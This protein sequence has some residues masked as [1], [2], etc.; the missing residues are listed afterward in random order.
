[1]KMLNQRKSILSVSSKLLDAGLIYEGQGNISVFDRE[2]GLVAITPS[3]VPYNKREVKD[4]CIVDVE[5]NVIEGEWKPT[6]ETPLH[7]IYYKKRPG[8]NAVI[9]THAP[10]ATVF[11]IFGSE[12]MPMVLTEAAMNLGNSVPIA[13]YARPGSDELA[14]ITLKAVGDGFA[15]IMAHH[16][17]ITVG[18]TLEIAYAASIAVETTAETLIFARA[19]DREPNP[20]SDQEVKELYKLYQDHK[21][22]KSA[23]KI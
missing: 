4:I 23:K 17:V 1:M 19:M 12:P 13:P 20:I 22:Q 2:S 5:G 6:S 9:H 16:G 14:E 10:K 3:A 18:A 11:G 8:I 21:P 15:A 7:L